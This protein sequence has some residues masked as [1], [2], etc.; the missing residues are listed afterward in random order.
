M[1]QQSTLQVR[2]K[3]Q[4]AF[5]DAFHDE[6]LN[7]CDAR[8]LSHNF[9]HWITLLHKKGKTTKLFARSQTQQFVFARDCLRH[10][11]T[12]FHPNFE[13]PPSLS[14]ATQ[15]S[16]WTPFSFLTSECTDYATGWTT[17]E[18][19][20]DY[21]HDNTTSVCNKKNYFGSEVQPASY[22]IVITPG[23]KQ[24]GREADHWTPSSP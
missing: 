3:N 19:G 2:K 20:F 24:P 4:N 23:K 13:L 9:C 15:N 16:F 22:S 21:R 8:K 6:Q 5:P 1:C 11:S 18:L 10:K 7:T 17:E 12:A 14:T